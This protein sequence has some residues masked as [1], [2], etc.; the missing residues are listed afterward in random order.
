MSNR[1][2]TH[3]DGAE[4]TSLAPLEKAI[5]AINK[6]VDPFGILSSQINAQMALLM[7]PKEF[8][9]AVDDLSSDWVALL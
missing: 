2:I 6:E 4:S 7:H 9:Q 3:T 1:Q 8:L 5:Q